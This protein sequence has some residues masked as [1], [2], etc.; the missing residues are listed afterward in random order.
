MTLPLP[1]PY[2]PGDEPVTSLEFQQRVQENFDR[3]AITVGPLAQDSPTR[4][5]ALPASPFDGQEIYYVADDT[6]G[7]VWHFKYRSAS[8]SSYK[9]EF[10]GGSALTA[11]V[12]TFE[13]LSAGTFNTFRDLATTGPSVTA[14]LAGDYLL[15]FGA[16]GRNSTAMGSWSVSPS[17]SGGAAASASAADGVVA[18]SAVASADSVGW[19]RIRKDGLSAAAITLRYAHNN[20]QGSF[21][22]RF[23]SVV[24]VRVG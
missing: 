5:T 17:V 21:A 18:H 20:D 11:R 1:W 12:N 15:D 16:T 7:V 13:T 10:V 4:V 19:R 14:P 8:A 9:W 2:V 6:N 3:L 24:P 23:L 22:S